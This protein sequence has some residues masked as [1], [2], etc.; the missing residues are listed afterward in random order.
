MR[1]S[2]WSAVPVVLVL[3]LA[4][5]DLTDPP[6]DTVDDV[7]EISA[8]GIGSTVALG[9]TQQTSYGVDG[10]GSGGSGSG[11]G[12]VSGSVV[13]GYQEGGVRGLGLCVP[14]EGLVGSSAD[15]KV[16]SVPCPPAE[17]APPVSVEGVPVVVSASD[18]STLLVEGSGLVRQ[19]PGDMVIVT[20]DLIVYTD[21]S[22]R[23]LSTTVGGTPV[24]VVV[25]PVSY[26]WDWGDGTSTTT[27][28]P[29]AAYPHQTVVHRYRELLQG[30]VV[31][32]TTTWSATFSVEGGPPQPVSGTVTTTES[33]AP[34][35]L[36]RLVGVLTDDAEEA[37]G[38]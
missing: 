1:N 2:R 4:P 11:V 10:S 29:G 36:V 7:S 6:A 17:V 18:V 37:Q 8:D 13:V 26:R 32:L 33:S 28:D 14:Q 16:A 15:T 30:V 23:T 21:P 20:K 5:T 31:T 38:H 34:F 27:R 25:T 12:G 19:P 3:L 24:S 22:S 35:D 9:S